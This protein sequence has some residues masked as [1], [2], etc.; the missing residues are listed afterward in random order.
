MDATGQWLFAGN[1][2]SDNMSLFRID[3]KTGN[4][5]PVGDPIDVFSPVSVVFSA[6]K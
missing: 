1:Q 6:I 4:L 2:N 5:N 3:Q